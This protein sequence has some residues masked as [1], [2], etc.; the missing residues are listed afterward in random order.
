MH[1]WYYE[2]ESIGTD[3][4]NFDTV[5]YG[6]ERFTDV[7]SFGTVHIYDPERFNAWTCGALPLES[8]WRETRSWKVIVH[9][10][11][12]I[13]KIMNRPGNATRNAFGPPFFRHAYSETTA[14]CLS[15]SIV[16]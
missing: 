12:M 10:C 15:I 2:L 8:I 1:N 6:L 5:I 13:R 3:L 11:H 7:K 4:E 16:T 14:T 9:R